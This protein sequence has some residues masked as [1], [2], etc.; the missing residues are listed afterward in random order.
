MAKYEFDSIEAIL[1]HPDVLRAI[2]EKITAVEQ[3]AYQLE[4]KFK[5]TISKLLI[6]EGIQVDAYQFRKLTHA[7]KEGNE[8]K[9][10][11]AYEDTMEKL[12]TRS[13]E[14][15]SDMVSDVAEVFMEG[16]IESDSADSPV[17]K[18]RQ[19]IIGKPQSSEEVEGDKADSE[20]VSGDSES[21]A[22]ENNES[23]STDDSSDEKPVGDDINNPTD[24]D[25][26]AES[27]SEETKSD[28]ANDIFN[29]ISSI[30][31]PVK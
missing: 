1:E 15:L 18:L 31:E 12:K 30:S 25:G 5:E 9:I 24:H 20:D 29:V 23:E 7:I 28:S 6:N 10:K 26:D 17:A 13:F 8:E 19:A 16:L 27:P 14:S 3:D 2:D 22:S 21:P 11:Q 4:E